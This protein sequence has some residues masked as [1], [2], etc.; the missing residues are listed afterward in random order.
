VQ[1]DRLPEITLRGYSL[2]VSSIGISPSP[3]DRIAFWAKLHQRL[4][5]LA[6]RIDAKAHCAILAAVHAR[7]P[8][9]TPDDQRVVLIENARADA[10]LLCRLK[11][12]WDKG[13]SSCRIPD[14]TQNL[15]VVSNA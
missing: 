12:T 11:F 15:A 7:I 6:N 9:P 4:A 14:R 2:L 1:H 13:W 3:A 5:A 8:M 10:R